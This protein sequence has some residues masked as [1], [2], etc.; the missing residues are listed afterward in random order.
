MLERK[1]FWDT[2]ELN[3]FIWARA[4][5]PFEWGVNDC[6][7]FVADAVRAMTGA[8]IAEDFRGYTDEA[9]AFAAIARV[10]GAAADAEITVD[11]AAEYCAQKYGLVEYEFPLH[12]KRGDICTLE[13]SGRLILALVHLNGAEAVAP[14]ERKLKRFPITEIR[15][16]WH[17]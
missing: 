7:L 17:V 10:T 16:A 8:D 13:E 6:A 5:A 3:D 1:P 15:R 4:F 12:A 11:A 2:R 9:G 14:G